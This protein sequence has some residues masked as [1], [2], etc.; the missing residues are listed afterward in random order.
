VGLAIIEERPSKRVKV[1]FLLMVLG[2]VVTV[3]P[4]KNTKY[5]EFVFNATPHVRDMV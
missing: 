3:G 2:Y 4:K 1:K 5:C